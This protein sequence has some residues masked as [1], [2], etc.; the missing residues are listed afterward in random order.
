MLITTIPVTLITTLQPKPVT[1]GPTDPVGQ[2]RS[3]W[4]TCTAGA[5]VMC[6]GINT[7][8]SDYITDI[9]VNNSGNNT[10]ISVNSSVNNTAISVYTTDSYSDR[11]TDNIMD[12][13]SRFLKNRLLKITEILKLRLKITE[14]WEIRLVLRKIHAF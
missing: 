7:S 14:I 5:G 1:D 10:V 3:C 9:D 4:Y 11:I 12:F 6:T 2:Q 8:S 13:K